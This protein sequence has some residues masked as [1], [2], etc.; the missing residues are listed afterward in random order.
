M[1]GRAQGFPWWS[2]CCVVALAL[3]LPTFPAPALPAKIASHAA[4]RAAASDR[5]K[6]A[7][8]PVRILFLGNSY[9]YFNNLPH[10]LEQLT[11]SARLRRSVQGTMV[12]EG[13]ATLRDHWEQGKAL[14]LLRQKHWDYVVL[15]E[16]SN[17]GVAY[18]VDGQSR[19]TNAPDFQKYALRF[20]RAIQEVGAKTVLF[21][22]WARED[23]PERDQ[24]MLNHIYGS[25]AKEIQCQ[26]VPVGMAW[27][28]TR[29]ANAAVPLFAADG[30]HPAPAGTY[31]TACCFFATLFGRDP[32]GL[33]RTISGRALD[34]E[35]KPS[36]SRQDVLVQLDQATATL[37]QRKAW[38]TVH[39]CS[40]RRWLPR[41]VETSAP[42]IAPSSGRPAVR[43]PK[44]RGTV[45]RNH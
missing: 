32:A 33:T 41:S 28:E 26:L 45:E 35:G 16:Q 29:K 36:G 20:H 15:Q 11:A 2:V 5:T 13:G 44:P 12:V 23:A 37:L 22:T 14:A 6:A 27:Q 10:M 24:A 8:A 34:T 25:V 43:P 7:S 38:D 4:A 17:L 3:G 21:Q 39:R 30:S 40:T 18:F 1:T 19:I 42:G 9:T 31:L